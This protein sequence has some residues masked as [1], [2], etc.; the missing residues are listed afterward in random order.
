MRFAYTDT[1]PAL[2]WFAPDGPYEGR[3][4]IKDSNGV[5]FFCLNTTWQ[6]ANPKNVTKLASIES[7]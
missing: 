2:P 4:E 6:Q 3:F 5:T 7:A 1:N